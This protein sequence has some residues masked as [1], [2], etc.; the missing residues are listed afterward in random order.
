MKREY[1]V[2]SE[3]SEHEIKTLKKT[4]AEQKQALDDKTAELEVK[5]DE[6]DKVQLEI[7][8]T[9]EALESS[10]VS[11]NEIEADYQ[12]ENYEENYD[13]LPVSNEQEFVCKKL[14]VMLHNDPSIAALYK[15]D[16]SNKRLNI[17]TVRTKVVSLIAGCVENLLVS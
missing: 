7:K 14:K 4:I 10:I 6:L 16:K 12:I 15:K 13:N 17:A 8:E 11:A 1:K 9:R 5:T 3:N 2:L